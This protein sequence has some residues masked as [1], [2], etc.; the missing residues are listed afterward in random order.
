LST[1]RF[2]CSL[3]TLQP[4]QPLPGIL[5]L[6]YR[7]ISA[8]P[9]GEEFFVMLDGFGC[10]TLLFVDLAKVVGGFRINVA[11]KGSASRNR[12]NFSIMIS[13]HIQISRFD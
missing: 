10:I 13:S 6:T 7:L 5:Q 4:S 12:S 1:R 2:N 9:E 3:I 11:A 8:L